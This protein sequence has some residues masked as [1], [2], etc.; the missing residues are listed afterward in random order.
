M[1]I[2]LFFKRKTISVAQHICVQLRNERSLCCITKDIL[3]Y[4]SVVVYILWISEKAPSHIC[5]RW[6]EC[7]DNTFDVLRETICPSWTVTVGCVLK[8]F[9]WKLVKC[10]WQCCTWTAIL[11]TQLNGDSQQFIDSQKEFDTNLNIFC[12]L[13]ASALTASL[14][15]N[16]IICWVNLLPL[17]IYHSFPFPQNFSINMR[18]RGCEDKS[19]GIFLC[20]SPM[21]FRCLTTYLVGM[22]SIYLS[23]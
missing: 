5:Y 19:D 3:C 6:A 8:L 22:D 21:F 23:V 14:N 7:C 16:N 20:K 18:W 12:R 1:K 17:S 13:W 11:S 10:Q 4:S 2:F 9:I 15:T